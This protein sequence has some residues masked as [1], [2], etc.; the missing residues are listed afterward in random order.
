[1]KKYSKELMQ[2]V[3]VDAWLRFEIQESKERR[4]E[5]IHLAYEF[6]ISE[7]SCRWMLY[8]VP[9]Y[10]MMLEF[11]VQTP[12]QLLGQCINSCDGLCLQDICGQCASILLDYIVK[13][14]IR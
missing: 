7:D 2:A 1:M 5:L 11:I 8:G 9:F 12:L 3:A 10:E 6:E 4:A 13:N 14:R